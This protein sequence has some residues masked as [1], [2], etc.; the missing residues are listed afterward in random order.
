MRI[1]SLLLVLFTTLTAQ[2]PTTWDGWVAVSSFKVNG[3]PSTAAPFTGNGGV[4][5]LHP[6]DTNQVPF[7]I[8]GLPA[9]I[10]GIGSTETRIGANSIVWMPNSPLLPSGGFA[11]G[12]ISPIGSPVQLHIVSLSG[13]AATSFPV[14]VGTAVGNGTSTPFGSID[15]IAV[16]PDPLAAATQHRLLFSIRG[17]NGNGFSVSGTPL[18]FYTDYAPYLHPITLTAV[19]VG[20]INA[21]TVSPDFTTAYIA[22]INSPAVGQSRI[23]SVPLPT[24]LPQ[25]AAAIP[26]LVATVPHYILSLATRNDGSLLAGLLGPSGTT[27][28]NYAV[29]TVPAGNVSYLNGASYARNAV[30]IERFTGNTFAQREAYGTPPTMEMMHRAANGTESRL[31]GGLGGGWG[32]ISGIAVAENPSSFGLATSSL[33]PANFTIGWDLANATPN[34]WSLPTLGNTNFGVGIKGVGTFPADGIGLMWL[35][36]SAP[37][38]IS[39][40]LLIPPCALSGPLTQNVLLTG[41]D[42]MLPFVVSAATPTATLALS[43][44][45]TPTSLVGVKAWLQFGYHSPSLCATWLSRG[46]RITVID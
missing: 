26:T 14:S 2:P 39:S 45:A 10:T 7:P 27:A 19:P 24:T 15:Q 35:D 43:I 21:L 37:A 25:V 28:Q 18:G 20:A 8:T 30:A 5:M 16:V 38:P 6:R 32:V 33:A 11:L 29:V 4:W 40:P 22:M 36:F 3:L 46:L 9:S 17:V 23:Y 41:M 42:L 13:T 31:S 34:A 1:L 12:E 44:P